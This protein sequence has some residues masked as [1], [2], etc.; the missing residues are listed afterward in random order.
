MKRSAKGLNRS[1]RCNVAASLPD[2]WLTIVASPTE[3]AARNNAIWCDTICRAHGIPGEFFDALWLNRKA[4]P[5]FYPN[6]VTLS[7]SPDTTSQRAHIETLLS[8]GLPPSWAVKDSYCTLDLRA[9]GFEVLFE[10]SWIWLPPT[11]VQAADAAHHVQWTQVKS[12]AVLAQWESAW[13]NDPAND[14]ATPRPRLF[15]PSLLADPNLA[16]LAAYHGDTIIAGAIANRTSDVVGLSNIFTPPDNKEVYWASCGSAVQ[17]CFPDLPLV[18]YEHGAELAIAE[19]V[20]F[21]KLQ[22]LRVWIQRG[23]PEQKAQVWRRA[24]NNAHGPFA[25]IGQ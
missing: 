8:S 16:F 17:R 10:A 22:D 12:E 6:V 24:S 2:D 18:G 3:Q 19:A 14:V 7:A 1:S 15:L 11:L 13:N 4:A 25:G 20:G 9:L 21:E 23:Q 5:R